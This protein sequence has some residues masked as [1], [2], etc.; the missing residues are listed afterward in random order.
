MIIA[1]FAAIVGLVALLALAGADTTD[2]EDWA[3][4]QRL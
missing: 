2:G 4:H 1:I 3:T